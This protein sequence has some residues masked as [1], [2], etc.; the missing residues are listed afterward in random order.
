[1]Y[2]QIQTTFVNKKDTKWMFNWIEMDT[3][4]IVN[5]NN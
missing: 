4:E 5:D 2:L 1:M 3:G